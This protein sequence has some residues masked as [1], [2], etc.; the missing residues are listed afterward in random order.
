MYKATIPSSD[1]T[2]PKVN[3]QV[4]YP[5]SMARKPRRQIKGQVSPANLHNRQRYCRG[6]EVLAGDS[7]WHQ[8]T[9]QSGGPTTRAEVHGRP[10][11]LQKPGLTVRIPDASNRS[12]SSYQLHGEPALCTFIPRRMSLCRLQCAGQLCALTCPPCTREAAW[13]VAPVKSQQHLA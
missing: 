6:L 11:K 4:E 12:L 8:D 2:G 3:V 13:L 1:R 9:T 10:G 5:H 7:L